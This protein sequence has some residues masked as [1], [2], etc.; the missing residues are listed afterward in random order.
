M[1]SMKFND[2][3]G[4][5]IDKLR[6]RRWALEMLQYEGMNIR[7]FNFHPSLQSVFTAKNMVQMA[8]RQELMNVNEQ[9]VRMSVNPSK[10]FI[11]FRKNNLLYDPFFSGRA[12]GKIEDTMPEPVQ[13]PWPAYPSAIVRNGFVERHQI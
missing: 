1:I 3:Y 11:N 5:V 13:Q 12:S 6:S 10:V 7:D 8:M 2:E 4:L 9:L